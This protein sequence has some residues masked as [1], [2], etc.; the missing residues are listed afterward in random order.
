MLL[1]VILSGG[2]GSRLW[3]LSRESYPKQLLSLVGEHT[4]LQETVLRLKGLPDL[5]EPLVVCNSEHRF[6]IAE[7]LAQLGGGH[8]ILLEP[9]GR[10]TAPAVAIA[11]LTAK[12][13]GEDITLLVLPADHTITNQAAFHRVIAAGQKEAEKGKLVTFGIVPNAPET[14]YGYIKGL[15]LSE[16]A[17][18]LNPA[19]VVD[20]FVEKPD[21][22]T[23][24]EYLASGDYFWNSGIFMFSAERYL[25]ELEL[26]EPAIY[27]ACIGAFE[28]RHSDQDFVRIGE[29]EFE[30]CPSNSIDYAVMEKTHDAV[31]IP[32]DAGWDDV[33]SWSALWQLGEKDSN[34]NVVTGDV[35]Y[36]DVNNSY[37]YS[38][39]RMVAA[40][41]V[42]D[43]VIVE[44]ADAV[45]VAHRDRVQDVKE[46]VT[47]L[48]AQGRGE[49]STHS[50]VYRPWGSYQ[51]IDSEPRFKVKRIRVDPGASISLQLHHHRAEH[52]IVVTGTAIVTK[53]D[54][55]VLLTENQSVY[56]PLGTKHRLENPGK[57]PLEIVEVQTGSYLEEDDIVRF[58][59]VYGR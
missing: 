20:R 38:S 30:A 48:K 43:H 22:A 13:M 4:M 57:I 26:H 17:E 51:S 39:G 54:E 8:S 11:A 27:K 53:G 47:Q 31:V 16:D 1:P 37:I 36:K 21:Q 59:D 55:Q 44:T 29:I 2:V 15:S 56:I 45:F 41:G 40:V 34:G 6:L 10:N 9:V 24:E 14:G 52:W 32:L 33:G 50:K 18:S 46:I 3:P 7:Q 58:E 28:N 12:A 23:A 5:V 35:H 19:M 25:R 49:V 42:D